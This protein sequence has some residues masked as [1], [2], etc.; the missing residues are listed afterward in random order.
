MPD[1]FISRDDLTDKL[2]RDVTGDDGALIAVDAACDICREF[3]EQ[4]FN[5][6]FGDTVT[7]DGTGTDSLLLP[8]LPVSN[9][10]TVTVNGTAVTDYVLRDDGLLIRRGTLGVPSAFWDEQPVPRVWP[11]GRQNVTVT[12]DHGYPAADLPRSV[13]AVALSIA[14]RLIVQGPAI[15]ETVG[16]V[17]VKYALAE[18]DLTYCE[19]AILRKY[20]R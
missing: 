15:E 20:R 6:V 11:T 16:D 8:Q 9:A 14:S 13:R 3:A 4:D 2:G 12:Y 5:E 18:T 1:P 7:L 19:R 17:R 10:G